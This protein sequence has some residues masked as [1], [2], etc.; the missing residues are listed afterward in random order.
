MMRLFFLMM[1][2]SCLAFPALAQTAI[3][4]ETA[5]AYYQACMDRADER[6]S[7]SA[8][9]SLCSCAAARMM[10]M[11]S[12]QELA[13][14]NPNPKH[15]GRQSYNKMLMNVYGPCMQHPVED[16]LAAECERDRHIRA[17][18]LRDPGALCRCMAQRTGTTFE[19][20]AP[21]IVRRLL[22]YI[23]DMEDPLGPIMNDGTFRQRAYDN[24][25]ACLHLGN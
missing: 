7:L 19:Q 17:F 10:V 3:G 11:M 2:L 23:P 14:M 21:D 8:Q 18:S 12:V 9:E 22:F 24:L 5:N 25:Y 13:T 6:I 4:G 1:A 15:P 20:S 16:L